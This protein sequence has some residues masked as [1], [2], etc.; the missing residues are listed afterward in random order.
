VV[1]VVVAVVAAAAAA[2]QLSECTTSS[3]YEQVQEHRPCNKLFIY[4]QIIITSSSQR[5]ALYFSLV[6]E[7]FINISNNLIGLLN[8]RIVLPCT[9][10]HYRSTLC[11]LE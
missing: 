9:D 10:D 7:A 6:L 8:I 3:K 4:S 1:V 2:A 11:K 5:L